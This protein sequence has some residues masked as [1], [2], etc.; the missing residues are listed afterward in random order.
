MVNRNIKNAP[1]KNEDAAESLSV[2]NELSGLIKE[3]YVDVP[4]W[5]KNEDDFIKW[6]T[7]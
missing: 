2:E 5:I 7:E 6:M 3:G 1:I 4:E